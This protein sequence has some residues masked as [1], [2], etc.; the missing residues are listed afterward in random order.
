MTIFVAFATAPIRG[1]AEIN[2]RRIADLEADMRPGANGI[3]TPQ[4]PAD[5]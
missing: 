1:L 2:G 3:K 5:K 4:R